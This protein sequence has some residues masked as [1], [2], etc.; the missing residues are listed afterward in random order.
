VIEADTTTVVIPPSCSA[1]V[2]EAGDLTLSL[3]A[4]RSQAANALASA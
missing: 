4:D 1:V 2:T 3:A